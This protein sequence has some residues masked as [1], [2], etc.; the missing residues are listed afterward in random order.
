MAQKFRFIFVYNARD[1]AGA[2]N[3]NPAIL[4]VQFLTQNC[5]TLTTTYVDKYIG[6]SLAAQTSC[7][8]GLSISHNDEKH[9]AQP[10]S[11]PIRRINFDEADHVESSTTAQGIPGN[12]LDTKAAW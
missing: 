12:F 4:T 7:H 10:V 3:S 8:N 2:R 11:L 9:T 6:T 1:S 5:P